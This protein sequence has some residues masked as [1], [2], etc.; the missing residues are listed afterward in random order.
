MTEVKAAE[1]ERKTASQNLGRDLTKLL[2]FYSSR[3]EIPGAYD[4]LGT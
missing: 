3:T 1:L 2:S 4:M